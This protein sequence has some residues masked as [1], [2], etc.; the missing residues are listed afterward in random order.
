MIPLAL[1]QIALNENILELWNIDVEFMSWTLELESIC[2]TLESASPYCMADIIAHPN[3]L[4]VMTF[5][6][7]TIFLSSDVGGLTNISFTGLRH[8]NCKHVHV[9]Q[10][11]FLDDQNV[12]RLFKLALGQRARDLVAAVVTKPL[13]AAYPDG[14]ASG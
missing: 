3:E 4:S 7:A 13:A 6:F 5:M 10:C 8:I 9:K 11:V 12:W 14:S 1:F 2:F